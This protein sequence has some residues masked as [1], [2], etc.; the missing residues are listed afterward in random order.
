LPLIEGLQ[1]GELAVEVVNVDTHA[2]ETL[3]RGFW[4]GGYELIPGAVNRNAAT[5]QARLGGQ[6]R[7]PA[8]CALR[9]IRLQEGDDP[10]L[11]NKA[12]IWKI[13]SAILKSPQAPK[14]GWGQVT[15][16]ARMVQ[17]RLP[18]GRD[19]EVDTIGRHLISELKEQRKQRRK[20]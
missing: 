7:G 19:L 16:L 18:K 13:A 14:P 5:I 11:G 9:V 17:A 8:Y 1:S 15:R 12:L 2:F 20:R 4:F 10:T 6:P 3:P